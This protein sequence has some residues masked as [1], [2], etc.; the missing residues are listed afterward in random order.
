MYKKNEKISK[1]YNEQENIKTSYIRKERTNIG[2]FLF[3]VQKC[4]ITWG[5]KKTCI[6]KIE[7][8]MFLFMSSKLTD[9]VMSEQQGKKRDQNQEVEVELT[10]GEPC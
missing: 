4:L 3:P 5:N 9:P 6:N 7:N 8:N 2:K 1:N 10:R